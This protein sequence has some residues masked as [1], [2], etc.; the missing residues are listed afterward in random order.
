MPVS[1]VSFN[2]PARADLPMNARELYLDHAATTPVDPEVAER[3]AQV[4]GDCF[5][6]PSSPHAVGRRARRVVDDAREQILAALGCPAAGLVFTSGAT[7]ANA[8]ALHSLSRPDDST[9]GLIATTSRD[10][11]SLRAAA[12]AHPFA[13]NA[14][15]PLDANGCLD[16]QGVAV[17]LEQT[18]NDQPRLLTTTLVCGQTGT[19]E[20][21]PALLQVIATTAVSC[22]V[23]TDATQAVGR[24]PVAFSSLG[25]SSL[26]FSP[27][28][29]GGPRGI[30]CLITQPGTQL[31]PLFPGSQQLAQRGGTEPVALIAGCGVAVRL[32]SS[33]QQAEAE[34]LATLQNDFEH[35]L[36]RLA[37]AAGIDAQIVGS[38]R[39][40]S[41]HLSTI[42]LTGID[43]QAFVMAADLVGV[44]VATGTACASGSHEPAPALVAM[45]LPESI[46][47][48]AVRFSYGSTTTPDTISEALSRLQPLLQECGQRAGLTGS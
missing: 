48:A 33:R 12:A 1:P 22:D 35:R 39:P 6:N 14:L 34:R 8:L 3:I 25:C 38:G 30:G 28:K 23:H 21:V 24:L 41:P 4:Q 16:R 18:G 13:Q 17:W 27:H 31:R 2:E 19:I 7:E 9:L 37:A 29:F 46:I 11:D 15:L 43:R 32:A 5:G 10:H 42:A 20:D 26:S 44:C 45:N 36:I 40:R 47:Q